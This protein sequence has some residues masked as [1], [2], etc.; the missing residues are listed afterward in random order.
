MLHCRTMKTYIHARLSREDR[1]VLDSLKK[2]LGQAEELY[3]LDLL[4]FDRERDFTKL[5]LE[6]EEVTNAVK[7]YQKS[8]L[9][10]RSQQMTASVNLQAIEEELKK[11]HPIVGNEGNGGVSGG[12]D[13]R[14]INPVYTE[15]EQQKAK[16]GVS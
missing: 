2:A 5:S 1:A 15:L 7:E 4:E 16:A 8:Y 10:A 13:I 9:Q 14:E 3:N 6:A 12:K 11:H